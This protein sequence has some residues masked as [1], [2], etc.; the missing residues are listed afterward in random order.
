MQ[1]F[2]ADIFRKFAPQLRIKF[3]PHSREY[4]SGKQEVL[5]NI[6][7]TSK[8]VILCVDAD[9]DYLLK[10]EPVYNH[11]YI[12]HTYTYSIENYKIFPYNLNII[13]QK[14]S[15]PEQQDFCFIKFFEEYSKAVYRFFLDIIYFEKQKY[16]NYRQGEQAEAKIK[17]KDI[18]YILCLDQ[19][20]KNFGLSDNG[21]SLMPTIQKRFQNWEN[22]IIEKYNNI[23]L[24]VKSK[25]FPLWWW[26][27]VTR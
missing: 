7:R 3:Y 12:F 4:K 10:N 9:L 1:V 8:T 15:L 14:C 17:E 6:D 24:M 22:K 27:A 21:F 25:K 11:P 13:V 23:D 19:K 16:Q 26:W 5:K 20:D 2:W 18:K